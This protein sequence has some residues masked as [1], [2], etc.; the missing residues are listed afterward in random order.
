M[1]ASAIAAGTQGREAKVLYAKVLLAKFWLTANL[2][3]GKKRSWARAADIATPPAL[4][5]PVPADTLRA[6]WGEA[7]RDDAGA[8]LGHHL[9]SPRRGP[10]GLQRRRIR[11]RPAPH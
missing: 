4:H 10:L 5:R 8:A 6:G 3:L 7:H 2:L 9:V 11:R 1:G